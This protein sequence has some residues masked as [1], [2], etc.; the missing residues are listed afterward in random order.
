MNNLALRVNKRRTNNLAL[1]VFKRRRYAV[2]LEYILIGAIM[3]LGLVAAWS[4][5]GQ[6]ARDVIHF[7]STH[8]ATQD[9]NWKKTWEAERVGGALRPLR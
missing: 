1:K 4:A 3:A 7:S 8:P 5:Y 2:A 6:I 9:K